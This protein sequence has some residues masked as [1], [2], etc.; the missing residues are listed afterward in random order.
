MVERIR[1]YYKDG[2]WNE[3]RV[4]NVVGLAITE[5]DYKEITGNKYEEKEISQE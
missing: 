5:A 3:N 1:D 2:F 4:Y